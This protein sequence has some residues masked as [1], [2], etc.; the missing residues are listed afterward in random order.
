MPEVKREFPMIKYLCDRCGRTIA[1]ADRA[2]VTVP[3]R[4]VERHAVNPQRDVDLCPKCRGELAQAIADWLTGGR[5][6]ER[7]AGD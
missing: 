3:A 2:S 5:A 6:G 7:L 4:A 1:D